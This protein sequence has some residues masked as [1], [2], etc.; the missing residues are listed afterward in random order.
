MLSQNTQDSIQQSLFATVTMK[1]TPTMAVGAN[2]SARPGNFRQPVVPSVG[3][4]LSGNFKGASVAPGSVSRG[5]MQV[6]MSMQNNK[7]SQYTPIGST[8]QYLE[9]TNMNLNQGQNQ[10]NIM[11]MEQ[12]NMEVFK[13]A[14]MGT[15]MS[16]ADKPALQQMKQNQ[17]D[18]ARFAETKVYSAPVEEVT[19]EVKGAE[20]MPV[21]MDNHF[22]GTATRKAGESLIQNSVNSTYG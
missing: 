14:S 21:V 11:K 22:E 15:N 4:S 20:E 16:A 19:F 6:S 8:R 17:V 7:S 9:G 13:S 18:L 10:E 12:Q 5:N 2:A 3:P 1:V